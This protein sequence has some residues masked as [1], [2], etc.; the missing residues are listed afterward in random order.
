[1]A[2]NKPLRRFTT[3][4]EFHLLGGWVNKP[5]RRAL[6]SGAGGNDEQHHAH[7]DQGYTEHVHRSQDLLPKQSTPRFHYPCGHPRLREGGHPRLEERLIHAG[8]SV[9]PV[10]SEVAYLPS[11]R[12]FELETGAF[13]FSRGGAGGSPP[14]ATPLR[15]PL[16]LSNCTS[17]ALGT[18][19]VARDRE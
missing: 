7:H 10:R 6:R 16:D 13:V 11:R 4:G 2:A 15:L 3:F 9:L 19:Q 18:G 5:L 14:T 1:M 8:S 17:N 12:E